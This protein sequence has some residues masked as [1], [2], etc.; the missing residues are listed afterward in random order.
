MNGSLPLAEVDI[1]AVLSAA[2]DSFDMEHRS[3]SMMNPPVWRF[4]GM[5]SVSINSISSLDR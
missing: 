5:S 3:L 4:D 2:I 1:G